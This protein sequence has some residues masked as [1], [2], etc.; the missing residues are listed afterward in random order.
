M[1][2]NLEK[3]KDKIIEDSIQDIIFEGWNEKTIKKS[4]KKNKVDTELFFE[5]FPKGTKDAIMHYIDLAD[6]KMVTS[7][8]KIKMKPKK[9]SEKIKSLILIRFKQENHNKEAIRKASRTLIINQNLF[10][11][12]KTLYKT[13]DLI[14]RTAG[15]TSTD[16]SFY[17][18]RF[19]LSGIYMAAFIAWLNDYE[20]NLDEI[21]S[22]IDR[23]L[24]EI[25]LFGKFSSPIKDNLNQFFNKFQNYNFPDRS[26]Q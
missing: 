1:K 13:I 26:F 10:L 22:F 11:S 3:I 21:E 6:R 24:Y 25:A 15:D 9:L 19:S 17:T 4:F 14:W 12:S 5:L 2:K 18:K 23:R 8:N 7:Y 16:F 20:N